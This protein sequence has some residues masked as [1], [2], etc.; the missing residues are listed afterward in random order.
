MEM[1]VESCVLSFLHH[2]LMD[3]MPNISMHKGQT[4]APLSTYLCITRNKTYFLLLAY[5]RF[6]I[7]LPIFF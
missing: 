2:H 3:G 5:L 1:K 6:L 7:F 4:E